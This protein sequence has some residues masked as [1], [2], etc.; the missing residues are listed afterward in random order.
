[1]FIDIRPFRRLYKLIDPMDGT[2]MPGRP[3]TLL[4][5]LIARQRFALNQAMRLARR[6]ESAAADVGMVDRVIEFEQKVAATTRETAEFLEARAVPGNDLL[7]QAEEAMLAAVDSL[8]VGNYD[9]AVLKEKDALRYLIEGRRTIN[10][11]LLKK[12]PKTQAEA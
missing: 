2:G 5:E 1:R 9:T 6:P 8:T 10:Q 11:E 3:L 12:P 7:F 4:S